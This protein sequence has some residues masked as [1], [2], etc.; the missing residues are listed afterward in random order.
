MRAVIQPRYGTPATLQLAEVPTPEPGPDEALVRVHASSVNAA[1]L[2]YLAGMAM[3]R[4][5]SPRRPGHRICGSDVAGT[6]ERVGSEVTTLPLGTEV[7]ADLSAEGFGAFAEYVSVRATA[8]WPK[9]PS[10]S[11]QAAAAVP[12]AAFVAMRGIRDPVKVGPGSEVLINGAG[13]GMGTYAL[14]IARARGAVVTAVDRADKLDRLRDLGAAEVIDYRQQD[15]TALEGRYDLILDIQA[16]HSVRANRR[17]LRPGGAYAVVGGSTA[18]VIGAALLG[19]LL[20]RLDDR[21]LG[22]LFGYPNREEDAR[23]VAG[24]IEAGSL[25]PMIDRVVPLDEAPAAMQAVADGEVFGKAI[26]A[27]AA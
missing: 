11:M 7:M 12:S 16:A 5:A 22:L 26:I 18:R 19:P 4:L 8:L 17:V 6:V 25:A 21:K 24:L 9:P 3:V 20:S 13:G 23:D 15:Y 10:L 14:Q 27:I 2:E 1:D